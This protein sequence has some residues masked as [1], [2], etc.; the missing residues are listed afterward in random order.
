MSTR[1]PVK[2]PSCKSHQLPC[3]GGG[4]ENAEREQLAAGNPLNFQHPIATPRRHAA[5][6]ANSEATPRRAAT[7]ACAHTSWRAPRAIFSISAAWCRV[8]E[9]ATGEVPTEA[10]LSTF[11]A[12]P[13]HISHTRRSA[14]HWRAIHPQ[15]AARLW[16]GAP[17]SRA[18]SPLMAPPPSHPQS[19]HP[20]LGAA[21]SQRCT[22]ERRRRGL[23]APYQHLPAPPHPFCFKQP[24]SHRD[25][26]S[27]AT[28]TTTTTIAPRLSTLRATT[29]PTRSSRTG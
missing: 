24:G 25:H 28:T 20:Q 27:G 11:L 9:A 19:G 16:T 13:T 29:E 15:T 23:T 8:Y 17:C 4:R 18:C 14:A 12:H 1:E 21:T 22:A 7:R 5:T 3:S 10:S 6:P 2:P 26:A